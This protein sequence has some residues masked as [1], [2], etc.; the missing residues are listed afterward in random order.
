MVVDGKIVKTNT[1]RI[2]YKSEKKVTGAF[3][4]LFLGVKCPE[5][6]KGIALICLG[7][8]SQQEGVQVQSAFTRARRFFENTL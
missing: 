6:L 8:Q 5:S 7:A 3:L 1:K 2:N 4:S